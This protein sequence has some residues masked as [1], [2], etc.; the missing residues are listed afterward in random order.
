MGTPCYW[1]SSWPG[2]WGGGSATRSE[3][4]GAKCP[5]FPSA[6]KGSWVLALVPTLSERAVWFKPHQA[7]P[8]TEAI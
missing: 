8:T 6:S 4:K 2:H 7:L 3:G 1:E 5:L